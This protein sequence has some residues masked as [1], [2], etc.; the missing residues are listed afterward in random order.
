[1]SLNQSDNAL[2]S[3]RGPFLLKCK[4]RDC[5]SVM[6]DHTAPFRR[7]CLPQA[8]LHWRHAS[9][10]VPHRLSSESKNLACHRVAE[11]REGEGIALLRLRLRGGTLLRVG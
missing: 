1:M 10:F 11:Q 9:C 6:L 5:A 2:G 3:R 8:G 4:T 7:A